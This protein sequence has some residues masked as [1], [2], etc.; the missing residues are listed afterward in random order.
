LILSNATSLGYRF[1]GRGSATG[2]RTEAT[3]G[4]Y[5][6]KKSEPKKEA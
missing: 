4:V 3:P 6:R 1:A 5:A 2:S